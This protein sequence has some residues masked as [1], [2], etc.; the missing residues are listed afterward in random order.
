MRNDTLQNSH[1]FTYKPKGY[2]T[3]TDEQ[4]LYEDFKTMKCQ[5][6]KGQTSKTSTTTYYTFKTN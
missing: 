1:Q 6:K 5:V 2:I 4:G 3:T